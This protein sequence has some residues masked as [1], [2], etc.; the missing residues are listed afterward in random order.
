[1]S[2]DY[3]ILL[4]NVQKMH[5]EPQRKLI[6]PFV[7]TMVRKFRLAY[8]HTKEY[9]KAFST[10]LSDATKDENLV[11]LRLIFSSTESRDDAAKL[12]NAIDTA[13]ANL[14]ACAQTLHSTADCISQL[15]VDSLKIRDEIK[16]KSFYMSDVVG[17]IKDAA[18]LDSVNTLLTSNEYIYLNAYVNTVKHTCLV[19][20][21]FTLEDKNNILRNSLKLLPFEHKDN[22]FDS[23]WADSIVKDM[24]LRIKDLLITISNNLIKCTSA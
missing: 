1:M 16:R 22:K 10:L 12:L 8:Y 17:H 9:Q 11:A 24:H 13:E 7:G 15:I 23:T 14:I 5:G 6:E 20:V 19:D 18:L 4:E 3:S 21:R 2:C